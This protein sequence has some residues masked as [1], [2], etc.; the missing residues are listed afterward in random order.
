MTW[1]QRQLQQVGKAIVAQTK[2]V[3]GHAEVVMKDMPQ[4]TGRIVAKIPNGHAVQILSC[5]D[6]Y[7][8]TM[9]RDREGFAKLENFVEPSQPQDFMTI[10]E[11]PGMSAM[12]S[13]SVRYNIPEG[14]DI[15]RYGRQ[16]Q[17]MQYWGKDGPQFERRR[18]VL[19]ET[20]LA[21]GTPERRARYQEIAQSNLQRWQSQ[22]FRSGKLSPKFPV[23]S[24][25]W[26]EIA[27]QLTQAHGKI[28]AV[29][30]MANAI[31]AGGG[32]MEG[33]PAQEENMF[34]RTDCHFAVD[35]EEFD[36]QQDRYRPKYTDLI[37]A[38]DCRVLLDT[39]RPRVCIRGGEQ[40]ELTDLG[41]QWLP[42]EDV[43]PYY[44]LRSAA[45]D[46]RSGQNFSKSDCMRRVEAQLD[47]LREHGV[48][49]AVLSAFGCGAFLNPPEEVAQCYCEALAVRQSDF[50]CVAFAIFNPGYGADNYS[51]FKYVF[52]KML[53]SY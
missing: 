27:A 25:D 29:L 31:V 18:K 22:L 37:N 28:F 46:L 17:D 23:M 7:V 49:H 50:D 12:A 3:D 20:L 52:E 36:Q 24:G 42:Q 44:E 35:A 19:M 14:C 33:M 2:Q 53:P 26:G 10:A 5:H 40:R 48:R 38:N 47:T 39:M 21:F 43:F 8:R 16:L 30:N 45:A 15:H 41:Y 13:I 6:D 9:W 34:R 32:Y 4:K 51:T 1:V 11:D